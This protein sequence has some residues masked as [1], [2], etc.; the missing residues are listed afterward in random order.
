M[1]QDLG[2]NGLRMTISLAIITKRIYLSAFLDWLIRDTWGVIRLLGKGA[3]GH[4]YHVINIKNGVQAALKAE[5]KAQAERVLKMEKNV[6]QGFKGVKGTM[7]LISM[8]TT[9]TYSYIVMTMCGAD[10]ARICTVVG[11]LTDGTLLRLGIRTLLALK[12]VL[13]KILHSIALIEHNCFF[14]C[15]ENRRMALQKC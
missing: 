6:L 9:D 7:Q 3:Y 4:V 10:L 15:F 5:S 14:A 13:L 1:D 8:G 12:Q 2:T 11:T